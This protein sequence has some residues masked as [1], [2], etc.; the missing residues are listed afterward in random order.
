MKT[1][2][3]AVSF[4]YAVLFSVE[5]AV[6]II[7]AGPMSYFFSTGQATRMAFSPWIQYRSSTSPRPQQPK[8]KPIH[9]KNGLQTCVNN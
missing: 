6:R 2:L 3:V 7:A 4:V 9:N 1:T 8:Q 5:M